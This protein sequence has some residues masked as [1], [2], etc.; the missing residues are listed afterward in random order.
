[1]RRL[2]I[3]LIAVLLLAGCADGGNAAPTSLPT[4][5][6]ST[7]P[8]PTPTPKAAKPDGSRSQPYPF[9]TIIHT[10]DDSMWDFTIHSPQADAN[11]WVAQADEYNDAPSG[12]NTWVG[13]NIAVTVRDIAELAVNEAIA[14][15]LSLSP[16]FV[17]S[18]G[19]VYDFWTEGSPALFGGKSWNPQPDVFVSVGMNWDQPFAL[20]TPA[21]EVVGGY[22]AV[23]HSVSGKTIFF[24]NPS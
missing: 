23:Q 24:G 12:G 8:T 15:S 20:Q 13:A 19:T 16:V 1:M 22:F 6:P 2:A 9:G 18:S 5:I 7:T 3:I 4:H 10:S 14:P 11:S 21:N 17:G